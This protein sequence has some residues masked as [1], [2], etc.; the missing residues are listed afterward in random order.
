VTYIKNFDAIVIGGGVNGLT[1]AAYLAR[2]GKSAALL[3][4]RE[5]VG[6][7]CQTADMGGVLAPMVAH[8][9]YALDPR[10]STELKLTRYGLKFIV[11]DAPTTLLRGAD[12]PLVITRDTRTTARNISVTSQIDAEVWPRYQRELFSLGRHLRARW[13]EADKAF[14]MD[15]SVERLARTGAGAWLDSWF[16]SDALKSLLAFDASALSPVDAGSS[17]LLAWRAAQEMCGLQAATAFPA[18]GPGMLVNALLEACKAAG[19][20][21]LTDVRVEELIVSDGRVCGVHVHSGE[22]FMAPCILS[23]LSR[24]RT[25]LGL[26]SGKGPGLAERARMQNIASPVT[27]A[28]VL[29]SFDQLPITA[30]LA[31]AM[32]GRFILAERLDSYIFAH[33]EARA[34]RIPEEPVMEIIFP[35]LADPSIAPSGGHVASVMVRPV[36]RDVTGGWKAHMATLAAMAVARLNRH[37]PGLAKHVSDAR[38]LTPNDL[39]ADEVALPDAVSARRMLAEWSVRIRTPLEG[40]LLCGEDAEPVPAVSGR[41]GRIAAAFALKGAAT[42]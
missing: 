35:T 15:D 4:A 14:V 36:P 31:G 24:R 20:H 7:L 39:A 5:S 1:A 29:L 21:I 8:A 12:A 41:A 32:N 34:G 18:G 6:G 3:E 11:R 38:V 25:L 28:K 33:A 10:V 16:E 23:S 40:L 17:L 22:T 13:W 2:A 37:I 42:P 26:A 19:V 30:G 27:T 9:I